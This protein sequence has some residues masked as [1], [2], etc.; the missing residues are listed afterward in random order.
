MEDLSLQNRYI[1]GTPNMQ[2]ML[3]IQSN[4]RVIVSKKCNKSMFRFKSISSVYK[5]M[6]VH[7][8]LTSNYRCKKTL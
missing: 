2:N 1:Q 4:R 8:R 5:N 3:N 6:T 7:K